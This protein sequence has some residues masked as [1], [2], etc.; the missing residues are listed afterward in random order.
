MGMFSSL[1][2]PVRIHRHHH[3]PSARKPKEEIKNRRELLLS[4]DLNIMRISRL[5]GLGATAAQSEQTAETGETKQRGGGR[6]RLGVQVD[7]VD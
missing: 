7:C 5:R 3:E 2:R 4:G 6:F 1:L